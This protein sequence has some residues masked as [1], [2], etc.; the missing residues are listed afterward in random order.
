MAWVPIAIAAVGALSSMK[1]G[2]DA[3]DA[4]GQA[5]AAQTAAMNAQ[6]DFNKQVYQDQK[7]TYGP[8]ANKLVS[9]SMQPGSLD[10]NVNKGAIESNYANA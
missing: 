7:N 9:E 3:A 4:A 8:L 5:T 2:K 6:L 10:W 1:S